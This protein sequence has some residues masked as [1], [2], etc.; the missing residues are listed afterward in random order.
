M[1][2]QAAD[3]RV[4]LEVLPDARK[5][6]YDR[7][8][9]RTQRGLVAD[10][11]V[12]EHLGRVDRAEAEDNF[13][14]GR[15]AEV[16]AL[17]DKLHPGGAPALERHSCDL[18]LREHGEVRPIH[19][20]KGVGAEDGLPSCMAD[21]YIHDGAAAPALHHPSIRAVEGWNAD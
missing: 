20:G 12:H 10:T 8:T 4:V 7:D 9:E 15:Y 11:R 3:A 21:Q 13:P 19:V 5:V 16:L 6:L 17:M 1:L 2:P 18:R 14:P